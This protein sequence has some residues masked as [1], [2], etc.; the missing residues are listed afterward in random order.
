MEDLSFYNGTSGVIFGGCAV[1]IGIYMMRHM[2]RIMNGKNYHSIILG[3]GYGFFYDF[4]MVFYSMLNFL[5]L[6]SLRQDD[7]DTSLL[8]KNILKNSLVNFMKVN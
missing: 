3:I 8:F 5:F 6:L 4:S 2:S 7:I 1:L